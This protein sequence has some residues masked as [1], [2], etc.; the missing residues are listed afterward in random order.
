MAS[1][2]QSSDVVLIGKIVG[3]HALKGEVRV[4]PYGD[5]DWIE[6]ESLYPSPEG[7]KPSLDSQ[8]LK[9]RAHR[10][11]K[12]VELISFEGILGIEEAERLVGMEL[13]V[14]SARLPELEP[15]EYYQQ[16]LLGMEV[17][18]EAGESL[19]RIK[20]VIVTG[21]NDV[22]QV[23]GP[24]GEALIP[25]LKEVVISVDIE[26]NTMVVRPQDYEPDDQE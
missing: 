4:L 11:H 17:L 19:G 15:G 23:R 25:A 3:V 22:Y 18:T 12:G 13:Y 7:V 6:G 5:I 16:D 1:T 20:E 9:V 26:N 21:A 14:D 8:S 10:P 24:G 2:V